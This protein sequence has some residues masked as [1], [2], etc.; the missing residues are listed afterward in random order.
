MSCQEAQELLHGYL[1]GELDFFRSVEIEHQLQQC[2]I[3][4]PACKQHQALRSAIRSGSLYYTPPAHLWK[5]VQSAVRQACKADT[6]PR[7]WSWRWLSLAAAAEAVALMFGGVV[8]ILTRP[9]VDDHLAQELIAGHVRSLMASH[10]T[11]VTSSDQHTVKPW[12]EGQLDFS[13]SVSDSTD[14]GFRWGKDASDMSLICSFGRQDLR[15]MTPRR[16]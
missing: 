4:T 11:D 2:H 3:C 1:D 9:A 8:P 7:V 6:P 12:F 14:Q 10:L 13:P 16:W 15:C 5:R